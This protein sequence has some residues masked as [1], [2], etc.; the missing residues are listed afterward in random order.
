[1]TW[2]LFLL[3][4]LVAPLFVWRLN[5]PGF[6]DTEGM[7][8]EPAREM[9]VS[10]D[11][12]TPRMNGEPFLTKPPL[13]YWLPATVFT[14]V[15]PTEYARFWSVLAALVTVAATG[16]L[17][18][19]LFGEAAGCAAAA[20]LATTAG[21][22]V[23]ARMLR[24][25]MLLVLTVTLTLYWY[26]RLRRGAGIATVAAFWTTLGIGTLDKGLVPL[27]LTGAII[28]FVEIAT[29]ELQPDTL[30]ARLRVL[31]A[32]LGILLMA[33]I[34]APWHLL[35]GAKNPG[36]LWDYV[37]NQHL[38]FF[39]DKKLPRDSIPD[40]LGFFWASFF[41]RGLPWSLFLP[42][43]V[44]HVWIGARTA[45][46]EEA[47]PLLPA[48]WLATVLAFFSLAVSRLEHYSLPALPAMA[49]LVGSLLAD[50]TAGHARVHRS[51]LIGP[52]IVVALLAF[53]IILR[54]PAT[55]LIA[56]DPTLVGYGLETLVRPAT[57]TLA[58]GLLGLALLLAGQYNRMA[59]GV[60]VST[61][62]ALLP[63]VQIAHERTEPLFS[64]RPF[65]RLIREAAPDES[66]VFF[67]AEDEYQLCGGLNY[68]LEQRIDLLAP[69][70]WV[71][72]TFL[73]G[74]ADGLFTP[75]GEFEREWHHDAVF[76][77]SDGVDRPSDETQLVSAPYI[78]V[79]RAG[80]RVLLRPSGPG[81]SFPP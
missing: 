9:V 10:G 51:W 30:R 79:A 49:L 7:F 19:E 5:R 11:W 80:E 73:V 40:A 72:P 43:A 63:F 6:S 64:W 24:T 42:G 69:P 23:E 58:V 20:V 21:F 18:R 55:L 74:R 29:G 32:P 4:V 33:G 1:M 78:V 53:T 25:D 57:L 54:D 45:R 65:A 66:R 60:G 68:Y 2:R 31:S 28:V 56:L 16:A 61:A 39:F 14:V 67:R 13:M 52:P 12:I 37:V 38:L 41:A 27:V 70:S 3:V 26:L 36:F 8:A 34:V 35:A 81:Y 22:F 48:I 47:T 15:G 75:R 77:I 59:L 71:P 62:V 76:F 46:H 17:G 44:V 50:A